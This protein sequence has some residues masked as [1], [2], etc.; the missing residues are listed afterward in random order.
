MSE[1]TIKLD[2]FDA[3]ELDLILTY[4]KSQFGHHAQF[5]AAGEAID[6]YHEQVKYAFTNELMDEVESERVFHQFFNRTP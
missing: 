5:A 1:I 3:M 2:A 6:R 4:I